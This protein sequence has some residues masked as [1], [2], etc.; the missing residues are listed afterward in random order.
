MTRA[1][2]G[3]AF[4]VD[5]PPIGQH[6]NTAANREDTIDREFSVFLRVRFGHDGGEPIATRNVFT[7]DVPHVTA[8]NPRLH[9]QC[10]ATFAVEVLKVKIVLECVRWMC[11]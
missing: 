7:G 4:V 10:D 8:A 3:V 11:T 9:P 6:T 1:L 2:T 5:I